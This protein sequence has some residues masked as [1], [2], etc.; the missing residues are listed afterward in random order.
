LEEI[1]WAV[2]NTIVLLSYVNLKIEVVYC[3]L[4]RLAQI[5]RQ[6]HQAPQQQQLQQLLHQPL[7]Q[8][9]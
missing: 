5:Q 1:N 8:V 9:C 6:F 4:H 2:S 7:H 3:Y